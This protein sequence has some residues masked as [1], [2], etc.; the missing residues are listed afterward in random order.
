MA[1]ED[2]SLSVGT[3]TED[4]ANVYLEDIEVNG[5]AVVDNSGFM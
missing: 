1:G 2:S 5:K 4:V 3:S